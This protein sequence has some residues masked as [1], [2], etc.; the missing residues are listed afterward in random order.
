[1]QGN[2]YGFFWLQTY[3]EN[4]DLQFFY[5]ATVFADIIICLAVHAGIF[6]ICLYMTLQFYDTGISLLVQSKNH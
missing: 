5:M 6:T 2:S 3:G 1:L 4:D